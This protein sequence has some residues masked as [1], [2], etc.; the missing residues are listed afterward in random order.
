LERIRSI[1]KNSYRIDL[2]DNELLNTF[3]RC[4]KAGFWGIRYA[5]DTYRIKIM[6]EKVEIELNEKE[7]EIIRNIIEVIKS[8][9]YD[10]NELQTKIHSTIKER[11]DPKEFYKKLYK[12]FIGKENG[13]K[14]ASIILS[15]GKEKAIEILER[16]I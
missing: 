1:V 2:K 16:Y 7:K 4:R 14:I 13:P 11:S 8:S 10:Y 12:M 15:I 3:E 9:N 5:N 6:E